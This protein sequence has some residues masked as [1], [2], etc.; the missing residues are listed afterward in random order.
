MLRS[1]NLWWVEEGN[2]QEKEIKEGLKNL[3]CDS[4]SEVLIAKIHLQ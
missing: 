4:L 1:R 2:V 3:Q